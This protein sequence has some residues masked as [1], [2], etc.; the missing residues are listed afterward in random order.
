MKNIILFDIN[1]Q[2]LELLP[3][4]FTR[5]I[6]DIRIG[7]LTI[8]EK[9][10]RM[11]S[12][13]YSYLTPDYMAG[14]Y[15][16]HFTDDNLFI[17]GHLIPDEELA[18]Q[19]NILNPGEALIDQQTVVAFRGSEADFRESRY[20]HTLESSRKLRYIQH[21]YDIFLL[22]GECLEADFKLITRGRTSQPLSPSNR[23]IGDPC[24]ADGT[25]KI[26]VEPGAKAE[27]AIFNVTNGPIYLGADSEVMEG[28]CIRAPFAAC[29]HAYVNM[30]TKIY[31]ATTLGP[32]CKVGGELNNVVMFGFSNKAHDGFLGNAVIGE[33]CNLGAGAVASNL[34]NDYSEIKLWNYP[35]RRFLPTHLQF[36]GLIM[37][38]HSK[39]GINTMFNTATV[40]GVGVNIHGSGFPRNFVASFS[41][42]GTAGFTDVQLPKFYAIA[43]KMMARRGRLL[44]EADKTIFEAIYNQAEQL[45]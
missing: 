22:N 15:P 41:E 6:A 13:N 8:R 29:E 38:D 33:W 21:L 27:C 7:I 36:C 35:T 40:I 45:K 31:G 43:E 34:K 1:Q 42:G 23:I 30:G 25:S 37:G 4:A 19:V 10:E 14:K 3:L 39:A 26:F 24:F 12:G 18:R 20:A 32:Y 11:L 9:W 17:A 16:A 44:T 2:H 28:S 5:P